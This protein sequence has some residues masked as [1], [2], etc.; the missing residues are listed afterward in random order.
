MTE[1]IGII[2]QLFIFLVIFSFPFQPKNLNQLLNL[3]K[4]TLNHIDA[5]AINIIFFIYLSIF[6]SFT[7][8][9][10]KLLF[11]FHIIIAS[12]FFIFNYN[13]IKFD[14]N[15]SGK[16]NFYIFLL[17]VLSIFFYISQNLK[18]EWDGHHWIE[19]SLIFFNGSNIRELINVNTHS[20]YPHGGSYIWAYFWKNSFLEFEYVG[21]LFQPYFYVLSIFLLSNLLEKQSNN[22]KIF[23]ILF[24]ILISFEPYLFAGYQEYLIFSSLILATRYVALIKFKINENYKIIFL[25]FLIFYILCWFKDEG[26]VY[27]LI[28]SS[29]LIFFLNYSL[30]RK[31]LFMIF[32]IC[33]WSSQYLS[34]K[35]LIGIYDFPQKISLVEIYNDII[36]IKI[37]F[38]KIYKIIFHILISFI[39]YPMWLL[40]V[41]S[42]IGLLFVK[43]KIS[44]ILQYH[45]CCLLL[46]LSFI[47]FIFLTFRSFDFMLKVSL[48]RLL[49]Q[50]SGFYMIFF[51]IFLNKINKK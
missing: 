50:T 2:L 10:I 12:I 24:I 23:F 21:R 51:I 1:I 40:T 19:K 48:D 14:I 25:I 11:K 37:L 30:K 32:L 38:V 27:F 4:N 33:L 29:I 26:L 7:N 42:I 31:I 49:F 47:V 20:H 46:N 15:S 28:F 45:M 41:I 9:D 36:N 35:Y 43:T 6:F 5:H 44:K 22:L 3:K 16:F 18:L 8:L 17:T 39:K 34:Q 13:E